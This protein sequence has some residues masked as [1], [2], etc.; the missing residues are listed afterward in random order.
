MQQLQLQQQPAPAA[1]VFEELPG[2]WRL[3]G[4]KE[5]EP[6]APD[7]VSLR[8]RLLVVDAAVRLARA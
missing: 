8:F 7:S 1:P 4:W 5:I 6:P 3:V 2:T